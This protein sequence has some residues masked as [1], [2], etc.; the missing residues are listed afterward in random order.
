M[1]LR[2]SEANDSLNPQ[3]THAFC[4]TLVMCTRCRGTK[5]TNA[6]NIQKITFDSDKDFKMDQANQAASTQEKDGT[7]RTIN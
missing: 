5:N 2:K 4:I 1:Y 7:T 3:K 6:M